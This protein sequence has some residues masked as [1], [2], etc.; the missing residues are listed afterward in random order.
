MAIFVVAPVMTQHGG[1]VLLGEVS[2]LVPIS[3]DRIASVATTPQGMV[4]HIVGA[5]GERVEMLC[6]KTGGTIEDLLV[7][8]GSTG[9]AVLMSKA[10]SV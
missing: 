5:G 4:I 1:W 7:V 3:A 8:V 9:V 6:A 2:K 10:V